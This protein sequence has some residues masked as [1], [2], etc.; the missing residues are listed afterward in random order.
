MTSNNKALANPKVTTHQVVSQLNTMGITF[1][2]TT[3]PA[4]ISS[5]E[6]IQIAKGISPYYAQQA[7][8][9]VVEYQLVTDPN[10]RMLPPE[11]LK[12]NSQVAKDGYLNQTPCYIVTFEGVQ[13]FGHLPAN[14]KSNP[15]KHSEYNVVIDANTGV[16]LFGF[17]YR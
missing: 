5:D 10:V 16:A 12:Q 6:A 7:K 3:S 2:A 1:D 14:S 11:E 8:H 15:V 13:K 4:K 17:D 9:I